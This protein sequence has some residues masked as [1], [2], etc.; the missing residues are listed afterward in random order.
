MTFQRGDAIVLR[1]VWRGRVYSVAPVRIVLDRS[2]L[3]AMYLVPQ[4]VS[5][6]S[7][8]RDGAPLRIPQDE[9]WLKEDAWLSQGQDILFLHTPGAAHTLVLSWDEQ[10]RFDH[11]K[12][13]LQQPLSRTA[14]GFDYMDQ[15]LDIIISAD[16][17]EWRW[18]DEDELAEAQ[19]RG[20]WSEQDAKAIR[21]EGERVI[22]LMRANR[23]PFCNGWENWKPDPSLM[24]VPGLPAGWEIVS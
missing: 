5:K 22:E 3:I 11:W 9:W 14:I 12:V 21:A 16:R 15:M 17:S 7:A 4:T 6:F 23:P 8:S 2:D 1:E 10:H 13:D 19:R 18:K 24:Q 20:V